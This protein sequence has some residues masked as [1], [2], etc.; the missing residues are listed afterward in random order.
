MPTSA[1]ANRALTD[2]LASMALTVKCLPTSRRKS[3]SG[4]GASQSVLSTMTGAGSGSSEALELGP[5]AGRV[6]RDLLGR[7]ERALGPLA[8][9]VADPRGAGAEQDDRPVPVRLEQAQHQ[10]ADQAPDVEAVGRHVDAVVDGEPLAGQLVRQGVVGDLVDQAPPPQ[11]VEHVP[12]HGRT[13]P[14]R[15]QRARDNPTA[16]GT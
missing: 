6:G 2:S 3:S 15:P 12:G 9:R 13:V 1:S 7:Q 4:I 16:P 8:A 14:E 5:D 11:L 10:H